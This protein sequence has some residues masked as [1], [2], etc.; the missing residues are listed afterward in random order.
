MTPNKPR[1]LHYFGADADVEG[2][3]KKEPHK[4]FGIESRVLAAA[5]LLAGAT[6]WMFTHDP[7]EGLGK[8]PFDGDDERDKERGTRNLLEEIDNEPTVDDGLEDDWLIDDRYRRPARA[9]SSRGTSRSATQ[10]HARGANDPGFRAGAGGAWKG[11][12]LPSVHRSDEPLDELHDDSGEGDEALL[13]Y[14][15]TG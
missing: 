15:V 2:A 13:E 7:L 3:E 14:N 6:Y 8:V 12:E 10:R 9:G 1:N 4:I 11:Y 5:A